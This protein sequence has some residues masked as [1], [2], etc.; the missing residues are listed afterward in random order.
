[1]NTRKKKKSPPKTK[2]T[3]EKVKRSAGAAGKFVRD[4]M[5]GEMIQS[6][7]F[8]YLPF[9]VFIAFLA[10]IYIANNYYAE[11]KVRKINSLRKELK[12][13]RYEYITSKSK[14]MNLSKQS[15]IAKKLEHSGVK[16]STDPIKTIQVKSDER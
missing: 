9:L 2:P 5:G 4:F 14:L 12:E 1:M 15:Q 6:G 13:L 8:R 11:N 7:T 16:E 3:T 10:F